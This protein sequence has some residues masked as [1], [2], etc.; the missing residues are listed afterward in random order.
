[1]HNLN[2]KKEEELDISSSSFLERQFV[3][4]KEEFDNLQTAC[5]DIKY[6]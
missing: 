3:I 4:N 1:M 2:S 5:H 6:N